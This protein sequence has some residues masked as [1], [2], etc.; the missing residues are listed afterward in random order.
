MNQNFKI[1]PWNFVHALILLGGLSLDFIF[2]YS[3]FLPVFCCSSIL[4]FFIIN[5]EKL[6]GLIFNVGL[7]NIL[8]SI[9]L[10]II[11]FAYIFHYTD[12][13]I[14]GLILTISVL[15][16]LVDGYIARK[17]NEAGLFG[18]YLDMETDAYFVLASSMLIYENLKPNILVLIPGLLRYLFKVIITMVDANYQEGR[19]MYARYLA[20]IL[21]TSLLSSFFLNQ[22]KNWDYILYFG[23]IAV[24]TSFMISFFEFF[25][26]KISN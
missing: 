22:I 7:A 5:K 4:Y 2:D 10:V 11:S 24:S 14:L 13:Y 6:S 26:Y 8:T 12:I 18:Q 15:L 16:D 21:F 3:I 17:R 23:I 1:E 9:R 20:G 19:K 25:Q